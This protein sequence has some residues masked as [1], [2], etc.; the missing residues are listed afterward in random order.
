MRS[1]LLN[2]TTAELYR[3]SVTRGVERVAATFAATDRPFTGIS[4]Q[5]LAPGAGA[6]VRPLRP[7]RAAVR[8][9][10]FALS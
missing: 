4:P 1:H 3:R 10:L 8:A 5:A 7:V 6:G 9:V 2:D